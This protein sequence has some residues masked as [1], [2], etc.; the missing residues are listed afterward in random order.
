[1]RHTRRIDTRLITDV[2]ERIAAAGW[3][4]VRYNE[5]AHELHGQKLGCIVAVMTDPVTAKPTGGIGRTYV[6]DGRKVAKAKSLGPAGIVRLNRDDDLLEGF[7]L[8]EGLETSLAAMSIGLRPTWST[9][10]TST[11]STLPVL[12]GIECLTIL[13]DHDP[14]ARGERAAR[15]IE[16]R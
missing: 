16:C 10:S 4:A 8:A 1:M 15:E 7:H 13:A 2:L 14:T 12:G 9:S 6:H 3:A 5:P 11:M